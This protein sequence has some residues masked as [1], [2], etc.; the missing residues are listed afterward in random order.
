MKFEPIY[1]NTKNNIPILI[2]EGTQND[3]E[4]LIVT[5]KNILQ[6]APYLLLHE[7][8]FNLTVEEEIN[9][10]KRFDFS[11]NS[12]F[13]TPVYNGEIIGTL[14]IEGNNMQKVKHTALI[15]LSLKKEWQGIG[16]G[17]KLMETALKWAENNTLLELILLEVFS[18]NTAAIA[19]YKKLG[20]K[21]TGRQPGFFKS[22]ENKYC[23]NITMCLKIK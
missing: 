21:E 13:L 9:W 12:L 15:G 23:D 3:A 20:F 8:E 1:V 19:L 14:G 6:D 7:D 22:A 16:L 2:R 5:M 4:A 11:P 10:L 17:Q 18:E